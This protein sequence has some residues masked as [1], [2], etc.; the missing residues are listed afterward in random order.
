SRAIKH[1]LKG[2]EH[3][4]AFKE[5]ELRY[6]KLFER[7][8]IGLYRTSLDGRILDAN[9]ALL[10]M[11]GYDDKES[12]LSINAEELYVYPE[13]RESWTRMMERNGVIRGFEMQLRRLDDKIIWVRDI[14]YAVRDIDGQLLYYEGSLEDITKRKQAEKALKDSEKTYRG[15]YDTTL[16]LAEGTD[17]DVVI[18]VIVKQAAELLNGRDCIVYVLDRDRKVLLPLYSNAP[19]DR[20]EIMSYELPLGKGLSGRVSETGIGAYINFGD[21]DDYSIYI[22]G[23]DKE[24]DALESVI[25]VPMFDGKDVLGVITVGKLGSKF[26]DSDIEEL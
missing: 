4:K 10:R 22:P 15:I 12:L 6:Q 25:S 16:A 13:D 2:V 19:K 8:P 21:K 18:Q 17:L 7:V 14:A 24:E 20:D 3:N 11:L 1:V 23:K 5:P 26:Q 9:P